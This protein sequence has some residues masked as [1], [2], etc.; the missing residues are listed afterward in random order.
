MA[1]IGTILEIRTPHEI[2]GSCRSIGAERTRTSLCS[3]VTHAASP[4]VAR[5][6]NARKPD[7]LLHRTRTVAA[8]N[9][10]HL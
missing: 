10:D 2:A 5:T 8:P 6:E 3:N 4:F 7:G 1:L 9:G